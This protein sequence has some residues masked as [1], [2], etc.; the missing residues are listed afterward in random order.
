MQCDDGT[1]LPLIFTIIYV[2]VG[3]CY[4]FIALHAIYIDTDM[5]DADGQREI[6]LDILCANVRQ[7]CSVLDPDDRSDEGVEQIPFEFHK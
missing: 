2:E 5:E 1:D 3:I 6:D 7:M 4:A